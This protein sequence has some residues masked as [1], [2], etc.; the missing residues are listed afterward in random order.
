MTRAARD[1]EHEAVAEFGARLRPEPSERSRHDIAALDDELLVA[2]QHVD[3]D[4]DLLG[5]VILLF[6]DMALLP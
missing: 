5:A 2:Q 4:R 6:E 1:L 3:R